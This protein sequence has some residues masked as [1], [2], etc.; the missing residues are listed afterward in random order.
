MPK[1]M[2]TTVFNMN[3]KHTT[4]DMFKSTCNEYR[5]TEVKKIILII[6]NIYDN[7]LKILELFDI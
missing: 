7:W 4:I 6:R 2:F 1:V 5:N 3:V